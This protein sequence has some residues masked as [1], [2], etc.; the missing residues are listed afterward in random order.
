MSGLGDIGNPWTSNDGSDRSSFT[1]DYTNRAVAGLFSGGLSGFSDLKNDLFR[2]KK[3]NSTIASDTFAQ[4]TRQAW[5]DYQR[6][7]VPYENELIAFA[8]DPSVVTDAM[9]RAQ[10]SVAAAFDRQEVTTNDRLR[11]LGLTLNADEERALTR[12]TG[13]SRGLTEVHA[14]NTAGQQTRALQRSLMG[15]PTP[16]IE[17]LKS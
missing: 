9:T 6:D 13:L 15:N 3:P 7:I 12:S 5:Q 16:T 10:G 1:G 14:M 17:S 8:N 2:K 11:G 4:L